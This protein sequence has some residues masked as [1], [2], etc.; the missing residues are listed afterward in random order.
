M[1]RCTVAARYGGRVSLVAAAVCPHPPVIVP[2][3]AG[4]AASEL[5]DL[6]TE[7]DA[8][9]A[10]LVDS[11]ART[12][13]V[14]GADDEQKTYVSPFIGS[15]APWGAPMTVTVGAA[16]AVGAATLTNG[17]AA[18]ADRPLPLSLLVGTWLLD[19]AGRP[20]TGV[21]P[22]IAMETVAAGQA[23]ADCAALG[24]RLAADAGD[25]PWAL[26]VMG[27]ASACRGQKSPGYDDPRA[28]AYDE[29][30]AAALAGADVDALLHLDPALSAEL[31]VAG[32]APWQVL[33][34]A[35]ATT[36]RPWRGR[37]SYHDAPYGVTY[38]VAT[39]A[40]A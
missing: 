5:D 3:I 24:A 35:V 30:V 7:C 15:F 13:V 11:G 18:P 40:P 38:L 22:A 32:R 17:V 27:D 37:L 33:A 14:V 23:P 29:A 36:G 12:I 4:R 6:R 19:R 31:L 21:A 39:W 25:E 26:L 9:V 10:R 2:D 28:R 16:A 20:S 8:A 1:S 34:G